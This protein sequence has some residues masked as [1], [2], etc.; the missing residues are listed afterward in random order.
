MTG[1]KAESFNVKTTAIWEEEKRG[2]FVTTE[3]KEPIEFSCPPSF[4]GTALPS[5]EDLFLASVATCTLSTILHICDKLHTKPESLSVTTSAVF[6]FDTKT[7]DFFVSTIN[8]S[9]NI[10]GEKF[11]LE[12]AC[13]L[14]PKYCVIGKSIKPTINYEVNINPSP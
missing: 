8:C 5:P 3:W 1:F 13:E 12:R 4:G 7:N 10:Y 6:E 9:I 11:L 14:I 2:R